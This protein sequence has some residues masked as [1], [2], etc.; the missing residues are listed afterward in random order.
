MSATE[1]PKIVVIAGPTASGKSALS[2]VL[3]GIFNAE[4]VSADSMQV[5]RGFDIGTAK[6]SM[7]ERGGI[8]HHLIDAADPDEDYTAARFRKDAGEKIREILGRGKNVFVAG[9]TGLYIKALT[10]GLCASPAGSAELKKELA[11]F[12]VVH[13]RDALYKRLKAVDPEA[14]GIIHPN[15]VHRVIRAL[16]VYCISRRPMSEYQREHGFS[17]KDYDCLKIGLF[18]ERDALCSAIEERVDRMMKDGLLDETRRLISS[19]VPAGARPLNGL[20]YKQMRAHISGVLTLKEAVELLKADTRRFAKR[21]MTW[22]KKDRAIRWFL[23]GQK[24]DIIC[25]VREH[26]S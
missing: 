22:F 16:E 17:G 13:G 3:A 10:Q 2:L 19:G 25:A 1:R 7:T 12:A 11:S 26:L 24:E 15:N 4:I 6:P 5:Y 20:G 18:K 21:Q 8:P 23:P 9:G 14:A